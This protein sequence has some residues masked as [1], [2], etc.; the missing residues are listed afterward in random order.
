MPEQCATSTS[1]TIISRSPITTIRS[2]DRQS[3][4]AAIHTGL[5]CISASRIL[6]PTLEAT[7]HGIDAGDGAAQSCNLQGMPRIQYGTITAAATRKSL[8]GHDKDHPGPCS[9]PTETAIPNIP[10]LCKIELLASALK[11]SIHVVFRSSIHMLS[12]TPLHNEC[13]VRVMLHTCMRGRTLTQYFMACAKL[14]LCIGARATLL[15]KSRLEPWPTMPVTVW[16]AVVTCCCAMVMLIPVKYSLC[17]FWLCAAQDTTT[18]VCRT[19]DSRYL[20]LRALPKDRLA[21]KR[22]SWCLSSDPGLLVARI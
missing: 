18:T 12:S 16:P 22:G 9:H 21:P 3:G 7:Y 11:L 8:T 15:L 17:F 10:A 5:D 20:A 14:A 2:F 19:N 4:E 13:R 1:S 6:L